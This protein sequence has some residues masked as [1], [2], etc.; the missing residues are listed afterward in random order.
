M[1]I[2]VAAY[3]AYLRLVDCR[4]LFFRLLFV[5]HCILGM[6]CFGIKLLDLR[7]LF[8]MVTF[9]MFVQD[10]VSQFMVGFVKN[11]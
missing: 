6:V 10:I 2:L 5:L 3:V 8:A 1:L 11:S 9:A 7:C 4:L